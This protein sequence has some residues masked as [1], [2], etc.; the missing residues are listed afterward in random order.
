LWAAAGAEQQQRVIENPFVSV[1]EHVLYE[2]DDMVNG[3]WVQGKPMKGKIAVEDVW[4]IL[5]VRPGQRSQQQF[6][7]FGDAMKQLGWERVRLRTSGGERAYHYTRGPQP[8]RRISV[9]IVDGQAV[10]SYEDELKV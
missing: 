6:D 3:V 8:H 9:V 2:K 4:A 7:L 10:A 1:L 5:G